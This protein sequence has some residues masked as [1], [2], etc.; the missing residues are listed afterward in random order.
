MRVGHVD[1]SRV[2]LRLPDGRPLL[3]DVSF[4]VGEGATA[5]LV[6]PNGTGKTTLLRL[7]AGEVTPDSG[8]VT[9][10]GGV[11][12]LAQDVGRG[13][14]GDDRVVRDLLVATSPPRLRDA[15]LELDAAELALMEVDDEPT[16]LRYA[17]A[18]VDAGDAGSY[19]VEVHWD[20]L[21][22]AALGLPYDTCRWRPLATLSG[23]QAKRLAVE[24]L[25]QGPA[26][27]LVLDEPDNS[28]DVPAKRWLE[29]VLVATPKSVLFVSHDREL[30][31][32]T[33]TQVVTLEPGPGGA[34]SWTHGGGFGSWHEARAAR[35]ARLEELRR[36]WDEEHAQL[37]ALVLSLKQKA[38]F[39][40]GMSSRY[41]AAQTRLAR[42]E[43]EGPP[44]E[45]PT[46][47]PLRLRLAGGRTGRRAVVLEQVAIPDLMAPADL[48]V[49]FGDRVALLGPNG[50]GKS[51][52]LR[53]LAAGGTD[54]G[55]EHAPAT[56]DVPVGAVP[57][58]G[59]ARLGARVRPGWFSQRDRGVGPSA[60]AGG[61]RAAR[62]PTLLE[63]L[64]RGDG[65]RAGLGREA[66]SRAL[67]RYGLV[68]AAEQTT[69]E[70][71]GGQ[72]A[73]FRVL[74]LELSGA[75]L[76]LLDEPTDDLDLESA[77]ALEA[78]LAG[79]EGTVVAVTHDRWFAR[80]FDR[81]VVL[82]ADGRLVEVPEPVWEA[83]EPS[84]AR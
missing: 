38:T 52:L 12:V 8:A 33:A 60:P 56:S 34:R 2:G 83:G 36:R 26:E 67:D 7:V 23:G 58:S 40:D 16:Q 84:P 61:G 30:L 66:A 50:S 19:D 46:A 21:T 77:E 37:R 55:P 53:L 76:L 25:L 75:T 69:A 68:A 43:D 82:G 39:N 51:H 4:R 59:T 29:E 20:A 78:A 3:R 74:L 70:L 44:P 11:A 18:L 54:P 45:A 14:P 42:F 79:F 32:R 72:R 48:E 24:A 22:R 41:Q 81:F 5:A 65:D 31:A 49:W 17:Q 1:V 27:V 73:R 13:G 28:L 47:R 80:G 9:G 35:T 57:H 10:S 64:H 63:V 71:S 62:G 6:G 15:L